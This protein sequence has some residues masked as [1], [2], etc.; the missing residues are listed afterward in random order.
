M[1]IL[2]S[3][4]IKNTSKELDNEM[5]EV[6]KLS[7]TIL[8]YASL[9]FLWRCINTLNFKMYAFGILNESLT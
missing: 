7:L 2:Q 3:L 8:V 6:V 9:V 1:Y 5:I 4:D